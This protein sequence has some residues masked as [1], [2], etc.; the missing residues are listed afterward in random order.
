MKT[1]EAVFQFYLFSLSSIFLSPDPYF[2][3]GFG[4]S[5][6]LE[7]PIL[8]AQIHDLNTYLISLFQHVLNLCNA[9]MVDV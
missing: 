1:A 7:R 6:F 3:S 5:A 2:R 9:L 8:P 4:K